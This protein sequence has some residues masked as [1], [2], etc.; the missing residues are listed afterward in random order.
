MSQDVNVGDLECHIFK[1]SG[2]HNIQR[3]QNVE[4]NITRVLEVIEKLLL[5][6][7]AKNHG[8]WSRNTVLQKTVE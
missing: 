7:A 4:N 6:D 2:E 3:I 5:R 1:V 8:Y